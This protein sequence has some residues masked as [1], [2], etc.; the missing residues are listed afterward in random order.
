MTDTITI[1]ARFN[2][3]PASGNGGYSAG[4]L[5]GLMDGAAEVTL[6]APPPLDMPL[7]VSRTGA[8]L[9]AH[10]GDTLVMTAAPLA[11]PLAAPPAPPSPEDADAAA[12]AYPD[13]DSHP[14]NTCFVCGPARG[15][16]D[17]LRIFAAPL[18]GEPGQAAAT[19]TPDTGLAG[20]DG[21]VLPEILWA[22]LD[23]PGAFALSHDGPM[24]LGRM[25]ARIDARPRPGQRLSVLGWERGA[26][27]RKHYA[28]TALFDAASGTCLAH[29]DQTWIAVPAHG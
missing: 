20:A 13:A 11:A 25:S 10:H 23:C 5:A 15:E 12:A 14:L 28:S 8:G 7:A 18:A 29:A 27:G 3:P 26:A 24:L 22:A 21:L 19:W 16:G 2:G 1:P 6:R 4:L 9:A 17:G